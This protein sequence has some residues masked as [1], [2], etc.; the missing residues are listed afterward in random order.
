MAGRPVTVPS[1]GP[2]LPDP[3]DREQG[4]HL[5]GHSLERVVI[6]EPT[7]REAL[8]RQ[9]SAM[10]LQGSYFEHASLASTR[11]RREAISAANSSMVGTTSPSP[12]V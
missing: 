6:N 7:G 1:P 2:T 3:I 12:A 5:V 9:R 8:I 11:R 4:S 10:S